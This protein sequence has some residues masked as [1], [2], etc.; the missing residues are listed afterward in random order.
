MCTT[1]LSLPFPTLSM[2]GSWKLVKVEKSE[3]NF[4]S[5]EK[6]SLEETNGITSFKE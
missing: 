3:R 5:A 6:I 4:S 1:K 2:F